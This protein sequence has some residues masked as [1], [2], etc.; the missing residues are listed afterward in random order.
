MSSKSGA[1]DDKAQASSAIANAN[2]FGA[3]NTTAGVRNATGAGQSSLGSHESGDGVVT[4]PMTKTI[5]ISPYTDFRADTTADDDYLKDTREKALES[6]QQLRQSLDSSGGMAT[7]IVEANKASQQSGPTTQDGATEEGGSSVGYKGASDNLRRMLKSHG[8]TVASV[9]EMLSPTDQ[10]SNQSEG[11]TRAAQIF[12]STPANLEEIER[13]LKGTEVVTKEY[14]EQ[15]LD[16]MNSDIRNLET[17]NRALK[18]EKWLSE[19]AQQSLNVAVEPSNRPSGLSEGRGR[20]TVRPDGARGVGG[21]AVAGNSLRPMRSHSPANASL[22]ERQ[23]R[24][25]S[26]EGIPANR[27]QPGQL[28]R[29]VSGGRPPAALN[30]SHL[31]DQEVIRQSVDRGLLDNIDG[32]TIHRLQSEISSVKAMYEAKVTRYED[33][34]EYLKQQMQFKSTGLP[35]DTNT[36]AVKPRHDGDQ[37]FLQDAGLC[38]KCAK[39]E[40]VISTTHGGIYMQKID[41]LAKEVS[42]LRDKN[43][44]LKERCNSFQQRE[45]DSY[46]QVKHSVQLVEQA[47]L[48][49]TQAVLECQQMKEELNRCQ[50]KLHES[51]VDGKQRANQERESVRH[52]V[53]REVDTLN[54]KIASLIDEEAALRVAAEKWE[55]DKQEMKKQLEKAKQDVEDSYLN[56]NKVSDTL[57]AEIA[58]SIVERDDAKQELE[59]TKRQFKQQTR[60]AQQEMS[61]LRSEVDELRRRLSLAEKGEKE[62]KEQL[63]NLTEYVATLEKEA[64]Q[65]KRSREQSDAHFRDLLQKAKDK[66]D[67]VKQSMGQQKNKFDLVSR[68]M[69]DLMCSQNVLI[70]KLKTECKFLL[71][72]LQT[73]SFK[74]QSDVENLESANGELVTS[75]KKRH[76]QVKHFEKEA[77]KHGRLQQR[78]KTQLT[79]VHSASQHAQNE[80]AHLAIKHSNLM[81]ERDAMAQELGFFK[82]ETLGLLN[83]D[84]QLQLGGGVHP[85]TAKDSLDI[86]NYPELLGGTQQTES[87]LIERQTDDFLVDT[88]RQITATVFNPDEKAQT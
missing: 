15:I 74:Y 42:A 48:E 80:V 38:I 61:L 3:S 63:F 53:R 43:E 35:T 34:I 19:H 29:A 16:K 1:S 82:T 68:D 30:V 5:T 44:S 88:E 52:E 20:A 22:V 18:S 87:K 72:Q 4:V 71:D 36:G 9:D 21:G 62:S 49:R 32:R 8:I 54:A 76:K 67:S 56:V 60:E 77:I 50:R 23:R 40:A 79:K 45:L 55:G 59:N 51:H 10:Q 46:N 47:Q 58:A 39:H 33:Q 37:E 24:S 84:L 7:R 70:G 75:L 69:D 85:T 6:Y 2:D 64:Y 25:Q 31:S 27:N 66:E 73:L 83:P 81:R 78:M 12:T 26:A 11:A 86:L 13:K 57:K 17:E 65:S 14:L 41:Q 28:P